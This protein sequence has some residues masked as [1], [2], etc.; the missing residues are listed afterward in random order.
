MTGTALRR[1]SRERDGRPAAPVRIAH[2]GP[3]NFF[4]AHQAWYTEHAP[5]A[6][7]WGIAAFSGHG[8]RTAQALAGQDGLY[9]LVVR[10][11][12]GDHPETISSLSEVSGS[13]DD[14][15]RCFARPELALVTITVTEAGYRRTG[16]G[17][18]DRSDPEVSA[19]VAAQ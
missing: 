3:G 7:S 14:W 1:L 9:T 17:G 12:D 18:L 2:L 10:A 6:A 8:G 5:D 19:D 16:D 13:L 11:A 4:R 15:R